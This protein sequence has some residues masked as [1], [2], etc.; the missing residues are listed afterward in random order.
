MSTRIA[1][2][3]SGGGTNLQA[4]LDAIDAGEI[5]GEVVLVLANAS[6]AYALERA[7]ARGVEAVFVS[8]K[9]AG[10]AEAFNDEILRQLLR[11]RAELVVLAGYLPIVGPQVVASFPHRILNIHPALIPAFCGVGMYGHHVHEAVIAYGAKVSGATVHFVD[12]QVDHGCIVMQESVPVLET[13]DAD[14][15]AARVLTVEHRILP[16]SVSLFCAGKLRVDGRR[17]FV[18]E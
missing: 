3:C 8:R 2:L 14:A 9:Q 17:V 15:L 7:R 5:D 18:V 10:S 12:E 1:V 16:R 11:V 4:I 6:R 13:D